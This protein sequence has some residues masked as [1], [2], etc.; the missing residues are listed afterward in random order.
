MNKNIKILNLY[1]RFDKIKLNDLKGSFYYYEI[2]KYIKIFKDNNF[3]EFENILFVLDF[4]NN[5]VIV[6]TKSF[7]ELMFI[8]INNSLIYSNDFYF[9]N[10]ELIYKEIKTN[11]ILIKDL[12]K[13]N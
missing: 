6:F 13:Y 12:N 11:E 5:D 1:N 7:N 2:N 4:I 8:D 3:Y 10:N 9:N